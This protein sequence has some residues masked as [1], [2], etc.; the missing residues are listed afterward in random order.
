MEKK[1]FFPSTK[2]KQN[3]RNHPTLDNLRFEIHSHQG[4][5]ISNDMAL[6]L[7]AQKLTFNESNP[8]RLEL[9]FQMVDLS[10]YLWP[11]GMKTG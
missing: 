2:T 3:K 1:S 6:F 7:S 5:Q 4:S 10:K 8:E 9:T 11:D